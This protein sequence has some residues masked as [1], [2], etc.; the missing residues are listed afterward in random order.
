MIMTKMITIK[1]MMTK[2]TLLRV[3]NDPKKTKALIETLGMIIDIGSIGSVE[4]LCDD[5]RDNHFIEFEFE[6]LVEK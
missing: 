5:L 4:K 3:I 2:E 6:D 1:M